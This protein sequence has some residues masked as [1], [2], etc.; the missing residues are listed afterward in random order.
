MLRLL[1]FIGNTHEVL[2]IMKSNE[3]N[4]IVFSQFI[5]IAI[6][7]KWPAVIVSKDLEKRCL[8]CIQVVPLSGKRDKIYP[9]QPLVEV[10]GIQ[11]KAMAD[12]FTNPQQTTTPFRSRDAHIQ[13][14]F[15]SRENHQTATGS[16][17][18]S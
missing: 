3:I 8:N 14:N 7:K 2:Q 12:Q 9:G 5:D 15:G 6:L 17:I 18:A 16:E 11:S 4:L 1:S 13:G 10:R